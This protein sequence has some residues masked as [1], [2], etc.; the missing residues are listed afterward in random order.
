MVFIRVRDKGTRHEFDVPEDSRL[1]RLG[2]VEPVKKKGYP[3]SP[4]SR[5]ARHF[6]RLPSLEPKPQALTE[7][8]E[9]FSNS[10][11]EPQ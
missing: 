2:L 7:N 1:L 4:I 6:V 11:K 3:P 5:P 10:K 9:G 8:G